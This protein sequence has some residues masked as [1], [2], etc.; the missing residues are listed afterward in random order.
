MKLKLI[1]P[2]TFLMGSPKDVGPSG[3]NEQPEHEVEITKP[4]YLG[5][6]PVTKGQFAAF[7]KESGYRTEAEKSGNGAMAF[8]TATGKWE[9]KPE[10]NWRNPGF[11]QADDHPVVGVT[12][13]DAT[14]FCAWLSK[15]E[16]KDYVLPTEAEWEYACRA[17]T[18]TRYWCGDTDAS[19]HGKANIADA[20]L[21]EK[22]PARS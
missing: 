22:F 17:G 4:F 14:A 16:G 10:Y 7:I 1:Q 21:N 20:S 8:L 6:Y 5:V 13:N 18:T 2:G 12:W 11:P 19:L 3:D 15:K 9:A